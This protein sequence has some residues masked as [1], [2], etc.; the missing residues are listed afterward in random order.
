LHSR[1]EW[2]AAAQN[3]SQRSEVNGGSKRIGL[4]NAGGRTQI[5]ALAQAKAATRAALPPRF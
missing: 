1:L 4:G 5:R 3:P 2:G